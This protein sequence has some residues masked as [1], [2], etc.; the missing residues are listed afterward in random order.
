MTITHAKDLVA[1]ARGRIENLGDEQL[2]AELELEDVVLVD[3]R[4]Q[5]E[6][7]QSGAIPDAVHIPRGLLE[8]CADP[9]LPAHR[10][11][12]DPDKRIVLYCAVGGRSALAAAT[13]R[14]M[15]FPH[16]AHLD[17]GFERWRQAGR[18]VTAVK[19]SE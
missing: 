10:A 11:E 5:S 14:D 1:A 3:L 9:T 17:G 7:Q 2:A 16:V 13:L 18:P 4:E 6:R 8:F 12:L 15:G 19:A